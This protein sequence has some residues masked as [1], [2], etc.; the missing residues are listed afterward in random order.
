MPR[1]VKALVFEKSA[2]RG[3]NGVELLIAVAVIAIVASL[4]IPQVTRTGSVDN[5]ET[6]MAVADSSKDRA[7]AQ[8]IVSMW[9]AVAATGGQL[10]GTKEGCVD[11]LVNGIDV[12][13]AGSS[14]HYQ[15][16]GMGRDDVAAAS[17]FIGFSN[18]GVPRLVYVPEGG[19]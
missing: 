10:P 2:A 7:N 13:F 4:V 5:N 19:Q 1:T 17:R 16:S 14:T 9:G 15:L 18:S 12:P 3:S 6:T 11:A 8:N